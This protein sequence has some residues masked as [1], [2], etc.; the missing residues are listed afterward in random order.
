MKLKPIDK[1]CIPIHGP[2][3]VISM[4]YTNNFHVPN[5][6]TTRFFNVLKNDIRFG[7]LNRW[8]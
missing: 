6:K 5:M 2:E 8:I 1:G 7:V 4:I 3:I